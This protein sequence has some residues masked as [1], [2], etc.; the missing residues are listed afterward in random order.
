MG[1]RRFVRRGWWDDE[2]ARE[3]Q[4]YLDIETD[5]HMAR[6]LSR[7][8]ARHAAQR[9]LGNP[10]RI[11]E[12]I[13][14]MNTIGLVDTLWQDLRYSAR[15]FGRN[16]GFTAVAVL[17]LALGIGGATVIYSVIRNV[18][19]DPFPYTDSSRMVDL[20]V[21]DTASGGRSGAL[22]PSELLDYREQSDVFEDVIGTISAT[23]MTL[24]AR[25][26][27]ELLAVSQVTPN[28]FGF[29]GVPALAGRAILTSDGR[30]DAPPIAVLSHKAWVSHFG[31]APDVVGR[32]IMLDGAARTIV[33][34]MPPRFTW[35]VADVWVPRPLRRDDP[36][37]ETAQFWF[38]ARLKP[39][40]TIEQ[41]EAQMNVIASRRAREHPDQYP[42]QFHVSVVTV[43]D[44]VVGRFR[45]VLYMLFAAVGL[46][47]LIACCNVANMLLARATARERE[48]TLR[49][50]LGASR[51]RL[52]RQLM[53]E[54]LFL[55]FA[56]AATGCVLA[57][58][59]IK[60]VAYFLP[61]Q[62]V[63]YEV[64]LRLDSPALLFSLATAAATALIFGLLPAWHGARRDLV[65]GLKDAGKGTGTSFRHGWVRNGLIVGEVAISIVLLLGAGLL[66]RSFIGVVQTDLGFTP[67]NIALMRVRFPDGTYTTAPERLRYY[68]EAVDR[69]RSLPGVIAVGQTS[70]WPLG[71]WSTEIERPGLPK[72]GPNDARFALCSEDYLHVLEL[73][74]I[75]GRLLSPADLSGAH[76][77]AV[78]SQALVARYFGAEDPIGK[79]IRLT[80]LATVPDPVLD[81]TFEIVGVV[82]DV[83]NRG[84]QEEPVPAAYVP[85]TVTGSGRRLFVI[86]TAADPALLLHSLRHELRSI[87]RSVAVP[88][89]IVLEAELRSMF[90]QPRFSLVILSAFA[91][92]GLLLVAAGVYGVM[93]Y[94]VSR[95]TQEIAIRM[96]LGADRP[97][98]L[99][100][101]LGSGA[102]LLGAG[103]AVGIVASIGTNRLLADQIGHTSPYDPFTMAGEVG[104]I[105]AVGLAACMLPALRAARVD[106]MAALR[107]E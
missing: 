82:K 44:F 61:Q 13:Y 28:A 68:R 78:V 73:G 93:A 5:E 50:A 32:T 88:D 70:D 18:L 29:L 24:S 47:L 3:L 30:L 45:G 7:E 46:L 81:P 6:G 85:L 92:T 1:W 87:D 39:G 100:G 96:A 16:P 20:L 102:Q 33:G 37:P 17:T 76:K 77:V 27:A 48:L 54:N 26:G 38:Q 98:L 52:M 8:A 43:I 62:G 90:A 56:A 106:P 31:S 51:A 22:R 101:V 25:E 9:K 55:A 41:A 86:R 80:R 12:E 57:Y 15:V 95:R 75:R 89:G 91:V 60:A 74:A 64:E 4:A 69:I 66:M 34:V 23:V 10:T 97:Q 107:H 94:V 79:S 105:V 11:R 53:I 103:I 42:K 19:L 2:R 49:A 71:G 83:R 40:T 63:P 72:L 36:E 59:G 67:S 21:R 58:G 14:A 99:R 65:Q 84:P 104:V 35:H